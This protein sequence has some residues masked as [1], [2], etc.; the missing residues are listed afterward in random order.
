MALCSHPLH[1]MALWLIYDYAN[2]CSLYSAL[3][4]YLTCSCSRPVYVKAAVW[5]TNSK[6]AIN[7][8]PLIISHFSK[9]TQYE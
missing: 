5:I 2:I 3:P 4:H 7:I 6:I 1:F 9:Q 8:K